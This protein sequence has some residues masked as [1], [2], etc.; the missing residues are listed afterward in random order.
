M[1]ILMLAG[2][3]LVIPAAASA[4]MH[5]PINRPIHGTTN[6]TTNRTVN[7]NVNRT[8]NVSINRTYHPGN[9]TRARVRAAQY[10]WPRGY[11]Y[12]RWVVGRVLPRAF[13]VSTYYYARWAALGLAAPPS[14]YRWVRYGPDL[15]LVNITTGNVVD[16]RYGVFV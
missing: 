13:L 5:R 4:Q 2:L 10:Y 16:I 15:L 7:R 9:W 14:G 1:R 12:R 8:T 11:A 3:A 6:R